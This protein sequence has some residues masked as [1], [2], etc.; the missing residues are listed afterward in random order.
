MGCEGGDVLGGDAPRI[1][2]LLDASQTSVELHVD[3]RASP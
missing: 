2:Y 3:P 1:G